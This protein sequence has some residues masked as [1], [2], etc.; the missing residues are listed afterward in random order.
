LSMKQSR[1]SLR[2]SWFSEIINKLLS[3]FIVFKEDIQNRL[4][5]LITINIVMFTIKYVKMYYLLLSD[6]NVLQ[7]LTH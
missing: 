6:L 4:N 7:F 5:F 1:F 2:K 3:L